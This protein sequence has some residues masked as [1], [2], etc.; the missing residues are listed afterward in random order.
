MA[1]DDGFRLRV[2]FRRRLPRCGKRRSQMEQLGV[3]MSIQQEVMRTAKGSEKGQRRSRVWLAFRLVTGLAILA[4][5]IWRTDLRQLVADV[6]SVPLQWLLLAFAVQLVAKFVWAWRWWELLRIFGLPVAYGRLLKG[7]FVGI[8]FNNFL[9]TGVGGDFVRSH[10]ILEDK[11]DYPRSVFAV[12]VERFIGVVTLGF[13]TVPPLLLLLARGVTSLQ[14]GTFYLLLPVAL[15]GGV[16]LLHPAVFDFVNERILPARRWLVGSRTKISGALHALHDA[17]RRRWLVFLLSGGVHLAGIAF[18]YCLGRGM[19]LPLVG[20]HYFVIV[21]LTV[22]ATMLPI[23]LNG[24]GVREGALMVLVGILN[25]A[26]DPAK[27][28]ALGLLATAVGLLVS[29]VGGVFYVVG[30]GGANH[31]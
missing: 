6:L 29:L 31:A 23:T 25:P 19:G 20:W 24:L 2:L 3:L 16:V 11:S 4:F 1:S 13:L 7:T 15:C 22:L 27:A 30:A 12:F 14:I 28:L 26:V 10:W 21:P 18:F 8:F 9:P 5:L 17:G